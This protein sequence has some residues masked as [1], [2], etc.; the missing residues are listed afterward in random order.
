MTLPLTGR[1][2]LL[3]PDDVVPFQL[4]NRRSSDM[5]DSQTALQVEHDGR[6]G[7]NSIQIVRAVCAYRLPTDYL[8][9]EPCEVRVA[10]PIAGFV[11]QPRID[12]VLIGAEYIWLLDFETTGPLVA[13]QHYCSLTSATPYTAAELALVAGRVQYEP[14]FRRHR[15]A[16]EARVWLGNNAAMAKLQGG[17]LVAHVATQRSG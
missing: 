7:H 4:V 11:R 17:T 9:A 5:A 6:G 14:V 1:P 15:R 12:R 13:C 8:T 16:H 3:A 10:G 2:W